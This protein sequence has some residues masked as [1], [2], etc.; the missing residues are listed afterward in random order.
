M[1]NLVP[2]QLQAQGTGGTGVIPF[3]KQTLN[4]TKKKNIVSNM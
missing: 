1:K 2:E 4:E 3:L